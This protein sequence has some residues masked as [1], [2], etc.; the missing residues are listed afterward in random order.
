[1][2]I[3]LSDYINMTITPLKDHDC[4]ASDYCLSFEVDAANLRPLPGKKLLHV[5][6]TTGTFADGSDDG[7]TGREDGY[8]AF[9][10]AD[11]P[12]SAKFTRVIKMLQPSEPKPG[13]KAVV[14]GLAALA[15]E[16]QTQA[17]L[18]G[19]TVAATTTT[20][21][22]IVARVYFVL[23]SLKAGNSYLLTYGGPL[24]AVTAKEDVNNLC[25]AY[26]TDTFPGL[27]RRIANS[28]Y[29]QFSLANGQNTKGLVLDFYTPDPANTAMFHRGT[30]NGAEG[31]QASANPLT[32]TADG[33][34]LRL[35]NNADNR[36]FALAKKL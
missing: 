26:R 24:L 4:T 23:L 8:T 10:L 31:W 13:E 11:S 22:L 28:R 17:V 15:L 2:A 35:V 5:T 6:L 3:N 1:M 25:L 20:A 33:K 9:K 18:A 16:G 7:G 19:G 14:K 36:T 30:V 27:Q 29:F 32:V 21:T 12:G 34:A